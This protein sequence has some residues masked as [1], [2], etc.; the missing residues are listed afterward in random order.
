MM[1]DESPIHRRMRASSVV[2]EAWRNLATGTSRP[3]LAAFLAAAVLGGIAAVDIRTIVGLSVQATEFRDSGA[4]VH[5]VSAPAAISGQRCDALNAVP[6]VLGAG[7][8]RRTASQ[9][10]FLT[11][12]HSGITT[13]EATA[14]LAGV[15]GVT[16]GT[17]TG[18][19]LSDQAAESLGAGVGT[20]LPT[21]LG[22]VSVTA[23]YSYPPD[24]SDRTLAYAVVTPVPSTG[25]FDSCWVFVWPP[26]PAVEPLIRGTY[27][28]DSAE[29]SSATFFQLNTRLGAVLDGP[30]MFDHRGSSRAP[31]VAALFGVVLGAGT[32]RARRLEFASAL[33]A[34]VP[35]PALVTQ[36]WLELFAVTFA[37]VVIT[38]PV[39]YFLAAQGNPNPL[40]PAW[41]AGLRAVVAGALSTLIGGVLTAA[42][43]SEKRLFRYFKD[44]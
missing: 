16:N 18:A 34:Q 25:E 31:M 42:A 36:V 37:A 33:H 44:R 43:T 17:G 4:A 30:E 39:T 13:V 7:A 11:E 8:T 9:A 2:S 41:S 10:N 22:P 27:D 24:A 38:L 14:G 26:S 5:V 28:S 6:G 15:L 29:Q 35:K 23:E 32:I 1:S 12:P 3:L 20:T 40:W 19:W 21:S